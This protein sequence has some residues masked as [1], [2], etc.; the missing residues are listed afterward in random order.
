LAR[1]VVLLKLQ[2]NNKLLDPL[3]SK[4]ELDRG[5]PLFEKDLFL[6]AVLFLGTVVSFILGYSKYGIGLGTFLI[7]IGTA[8][9]R[10]YSAGNEEYIYRRHHDNHHK[11]K[12]SLFSQNVLLGSPTSKTQKTYVKK[13]L[14]IEKNKTFPNITCDI[15][16]D[17]NK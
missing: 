9:A 15:P 3:N 12:T 7:F 8:A 1:L 2:N 16:F 5:G 11:N 6:V 10:Y 14:I 13:F 4:N 17:Y